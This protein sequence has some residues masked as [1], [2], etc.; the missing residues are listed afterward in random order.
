MFVASWMGVDKDGLVI[1]SEY[2][3]LCGGWGGG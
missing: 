1:G 2:I 3:Y